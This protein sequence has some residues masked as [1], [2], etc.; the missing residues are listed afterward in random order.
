MIALVRTGVSALSTLLGL[1]PGNDSA[2]GRPTPNALIN[3]VRNTLPREVVWGWCDCFFVLF[4]GGG[5][6]GAPSAHPAAPLLPVAMKGQHRQE[7]TSHRAALR[8]QYSCISATLA[9]ISQLKQ[10]RN[11]DNISSSL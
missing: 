11:E 10:S 5:G 9:F 6:G 1:S 8:D 4:L 7:I 3:R 2:G